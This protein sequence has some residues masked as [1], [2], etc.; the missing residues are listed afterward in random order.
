MLKDSNTYLGF[1]FGTKSIGIAVGQAITATARP[2]TSIKA[3]NGKPN[4]QEIKDIIKEW[5]PEGLIVGIPLNM[6]GTEN[7]VTPL[8][9][10]FAETLHSVTHKSVFECDERLTTIEAREILFEKKRKKGLVKSDIDSYSAKLILESWFR[11][12]EE[13]SNV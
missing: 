12:K 13:K 2:L 9:K 4:W 5:K 10:K 7:S 6:D 3:N 1:D 8:A 11:S